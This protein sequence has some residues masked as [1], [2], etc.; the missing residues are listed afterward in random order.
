MLRIRNCVLK[1]S[2]NFKEIPS[3]FK[4]VY[5]LNYYDPS[6]NNIEFC[7]E[8]A[9]RKTQNRNEENLFHR[10]SINV[11]NPEILSNLIIEWELWIPLENLEKKLVKTTCLYK[12][13]FQILNKLLNFENKSQLYHSNLFLKYNL[14]EKLINFLLDANEEN[15]ILDSMACSELINIFKHFNSIFTWSSADG[16]TGSKTITKRLFSNFFDY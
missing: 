3:F 13:A 1:I 12:F 4:P 15:F 14:L 16:Q 5:R 2:A 9:W 7:Y 11:I 8:S 10:S 6:P